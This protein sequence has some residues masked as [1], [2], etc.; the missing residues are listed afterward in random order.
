MLQWH[1]PHLRIHV[2]LRYGWMLQWIHG[3]TLQALYYAVY[4]TCKLL[5]ILH[6]VTPD[7]T[8]CFPYTAKCPADCHL[9]AN[10]RGSE[11]AIH[12]ER[13]IVACCALN[14]SGVL[15]L[16]YYA[17]FVVCSISF[18]CYRN[19]NILYEHGYTKYVNL[20]PRCRAVRWL[21]CSCSPWR[22]GQGSLS[23]FPVTPVSDACDW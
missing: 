11:Q 21:S 13:S 17:Q 9:L 23:W 19:Q 22:T 16:L 4:I 7:R 12:I 20:N 14:P 18:I 1:C 2:T 15:G 6:T 10:L 5:H 3:L 8:D